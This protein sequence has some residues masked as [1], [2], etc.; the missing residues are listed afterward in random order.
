MKSTH[1]NGSKSV[2]VNGHDD[3]V[4]NAINYGG[5]KRMNFQMLFLRFESVVTMPIELFLAQEVCY[6]KI[7]SS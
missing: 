6:Q 1:S 2:L 5:N 4:D 7:K 3:S